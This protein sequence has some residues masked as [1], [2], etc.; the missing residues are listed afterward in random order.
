MRATRAS[1][2]FCTSKPV[3]PPDDFD[4]GSS[5]WARYLASLA[6]R[7]PR[8]YS[9]AYF[10]SK[11]SQPLSGAR[12]CGRYTLF[13]CAAQSL[14]SPHEPNITYLLLAISSTIA[15]ISASS[16]FAV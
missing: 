7:V 16:A 12:S 10:G 1:P 4:V 11:G 13:F 15:S 14:S 6:L 2:D 3:P 9:V 8:W 5:S